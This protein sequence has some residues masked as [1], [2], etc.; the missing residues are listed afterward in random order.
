[1]EKRRITQRLAWPWTVLSAMASAWLLLVFVLSKTVG[2][3]N[4]DEVYFSHIFWLIFQGKRPF[5]DF[6]AQHFPTYFLLYDPVIPRPSPNDLDFIWLIR[7]SNLAV[8]AAYVT[9]LFAVARRWAIALLPLLLLLATV[10]RMIEI[11]A[12]TLG[13]LAFN[14]A[15]A[16]LLVSNSRR[17]TAIASL[18]AIVAATFS[19]RALIVGLG[20]GAALVWRSFVNRDF[21][22]LI[23]PTTLLAGA[24]VA[25]AAAYFLN[26]G[27]VQLLLDS[28]LFSPSR[29]LTHLTLAQRIFALDRLPQI[30]IAAAALLLGIVS[31]VKRTDRDRGGIVAIASLTQLIL[32]F[33]DPSPFPYVYAWT[34][35][36]SLVG[37]TLADG[38]FRFD[39]RRLLAAAGAAGGA[40]IAIAILS[41]PAVTGR[42]APTGSNYRLMPDARIPPETAR[43]MPVDALVMLMLARDRQQSLG[44][45]LLVR[46]ELCRRIDGT[47]MSVWQTHPICLPDASYEWWSYRWPD[48]GL[49]GELA[50]HDAWFQRIFRERAPSLFIWDPRLPGAQVHLNSRIL[51]HLADYEVGPGYALRKGTPMAATNS[52]GRAASRPNSARR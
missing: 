47:V 5:L 21:K 11:R 2:P 32:I 1:M 13:L 37:L 15:W 7:L 48:I 49:D 14:A 42:R 19:A 9:I 3:L 31:V 43:Q 46:E 38:L 17:S 33:V 22:S 44:N 35:I 26:P 36:P 34:V 52:S 27:Y 41:Y 51:G 28:T 23:V 45:Q 8:L 4:P 24:A 16:A 12:D 18:L 30:L 50:P 29:L 40:M 6:Y 25:G 20:F 39:A 10:S